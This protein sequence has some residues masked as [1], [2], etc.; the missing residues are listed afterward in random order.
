MKSEDYLLVTKEL[1]SSPNEQD[2]QLGDEL[3]K[4]GNVCISAPWSLNIL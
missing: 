3:N 4:M 1:S 2:R